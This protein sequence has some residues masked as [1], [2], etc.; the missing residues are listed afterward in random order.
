MGE[1]KPLGP[2][3]KTSRWLRGG[4][5]MRLVGV[6]WDYVLMMGIW[7]ALT[8][9]ERRA[10]LQAMISRPLVA[11]AVTGL[12]LDDAR[13]GLLIGV[14]FELL[15]L[16]GASLG[17]AQAE[18]ETLPTV[19]AA[20]MASAMGDE[21]GG[22]ATWAMMTISVLLFAPA[23]LLGRALEA[24]LDARANRYAVRLREAVDAGDLERAV[25]QNLRALWPQFAFYGLISAVAVLVGF[26]VAP[27]EHQLP[28]LLLR[29][30]A[31][32]WPVMGVAAAGVALQGNRARGR[33]A[34][35][36][37]AA[38]LMLVG[39]FGTLLWGPAWR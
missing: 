31:W 37:V 23:G 12:L 35:A 21:S 30:L 3:G 27:L 4:Q 20:A 19:A 25:Q 24:R 1:V 8:S 14:L 17:G 2:V 11:G 18:H 6:H 9:V 32:A 16:G 13:A 10:F 33:F 38:T 22:D 36:G 7:G 28:T 5:K 15:Y 29:G 39:V 34:W 26:L